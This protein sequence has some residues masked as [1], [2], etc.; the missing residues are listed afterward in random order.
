MKG[1]KLK[2]DDGAGGDIKLWHN[3]DKTPS[4]QLISR[5]TSALVNDV[6]THSISTGAA[7]AETVNNYIG[8]DWD[9]GHILLVQRA[10]SAPGIPG[11]PQN[12]PLARVQRGTEATYGRLPG[13][14]RIPNF[15][16]ALVD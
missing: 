14:Q 8:A 12:L 2:F 6:K 16:I 4:E 5:R 9:I 15:T 1:Q 3:F 7:S 13:V 11:R 10:A